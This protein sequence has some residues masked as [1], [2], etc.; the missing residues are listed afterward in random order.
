[1]PTQVSKKRLVI[2]GDILELYEYRYPYAFNY[3][4]YKNN[5]TGEKK[6]NPRRED[7]LRKV[8]TQ[9]RRLVEANYKSYG[10]EPVFLTFTFKDNVRSV[11]LATSRFT[12][13]VRRFKYHSGITLRYLSVVEFQKRGAVHF[14]CIFFNLPLA[15]ERSERDTR[16]ISKIW[17]HGF[18]DIQRIRNADAVGPYVCKYLNKSVMDSRLIGK[19]AFFTSRGLLRPVEYRLSE[20]VDKVLAKWQCYDL[21]LMHSSEY[22]TVGFNHI[23][24]TQY[25][26][27][28]VRS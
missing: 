27:R 6:E 20:V 7:N 16:Y 28:S 26:R 4:P 19:K 2:S 3:S 14:H 17:G 22:E 9:I 1:M 12:D 10:Y 13:F 24:Y 21:Q 11:L 25:E 5:S 8:R 18:I 23:K 15:F